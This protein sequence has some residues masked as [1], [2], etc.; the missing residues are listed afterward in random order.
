MRKPKLDKT[1][2]KKEPKAA[3]VVAGSNSADPEMRALFLAD[4]ERY[5]KASERQ[6]KATAD[7]RNIAKQIKADGFT[8][9][10]VKLA[11][12]LDT[13]EGEADFKSLIA[14]DLLAAQYVGAA[15]GSQLQLFL[16]PD[17]TPAVDSAYADGQKASME[18]KSA[19]PPYDPST[20]QAMRW[21]EG[22]NDDTARRVKSG[23]KPL[24][25]DAPPRAQDM[26]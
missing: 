26:N 14:N 22:F 16:E 23:I 13:P 1:D 6:K 9:R 8:L 21:L 7:V 20:P 10:Q 19:K 2:A 5:A 4:K 24:A 3:K 18:G 15:I 12:Q 11:I 17:R 25:E